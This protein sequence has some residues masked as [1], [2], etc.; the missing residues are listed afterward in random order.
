MEADTVGKPGLGVR[1]PAAITVEVGQRD[2]AFGPLDQRT[3]HGLV[4][5]ERRVKARALIRRQAEGG[6]GANTRAASRRTARTGSSSSG[7][8]AGARSCGSTLPSAL[9]AASRTIGS[10]SARPC[11]IAGKVDGSSWCSNDATAVARTMAG[12]VWSAELDQPLRRAG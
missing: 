10:G 1:Q 11:W 12:A 2:Q 8:S 3:L 9:T 6:T 4:V 7:S 5:G